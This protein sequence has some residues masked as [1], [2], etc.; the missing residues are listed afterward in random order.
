MVCTYNWFHKEKVVAYT[1]D[2]NEC[3]A[4]NN[5]PGARISLSTQTH[6][7]DTPMR[8][9]FENGPGQAVPLSLKLPPALPTWTFKQR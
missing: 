4:F 3:S 2:L 1:L 7:Q 9:G 6:Q 5:K 8:Q